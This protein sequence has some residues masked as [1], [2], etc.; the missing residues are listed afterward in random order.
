MFVVSEDETVRRFPTAW[1]DRLRTDAAVRLP[2]YANQRLRVAEV[3][4][5]SADRFAMRL[6]IHTTLFLSFDATG[7]LDKDPQQWLR[8]AGEYL[9]VAMAPP[10]DTAARFLKRRLDHQHRWEVPPR[11]FAHIADAVFGV[12]AWRPPPGGSSRGGGRCKRRC[13]D[14]PLKRP[15]TPVAAV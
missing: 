11:I 2:E 6:K 3:V 4:V 9:D 15:D 5:E 14:G 7:A 10:A 1:Y 8:E 12:D 13:K